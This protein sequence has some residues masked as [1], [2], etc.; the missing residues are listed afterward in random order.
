MSCRPS[1][2]GITRS[3]I[4][5]S[6]WFLDRYCSASREE[7]TPTAEWPSSLHTR[8]SMSLTDTSSSTTRI[9]TARQ[10]AHSRG[11]FRKVKRQKAEGKK[12]ECSRA[13]KADGGGVDSEGDPQLGLP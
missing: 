11:D 1:G 5:R 8:A 10:S 3:A 9:R 4:N 13:L 12:G 2:G 7:L 6:T